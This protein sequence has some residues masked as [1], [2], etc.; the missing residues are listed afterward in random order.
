MVQA[1]EEMFLYI[2]KEMYASNLSCSHD[3]TF[4]GARNVYLLS[5]VSGRSER[6]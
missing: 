2:A 5:A 4:Y 3:A 6:L 1:N